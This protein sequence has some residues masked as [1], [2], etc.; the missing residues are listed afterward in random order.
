MADR[1][2]EVAL[3]EIQAALVEVYE[4]DHHQL[5]EQPPDV[6]GRYLMEQRGLKQADLVPVSFS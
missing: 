1:P 5:P 4:K 2:E 6:M 3:P